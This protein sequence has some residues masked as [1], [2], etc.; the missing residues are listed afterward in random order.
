MNKHERLIEDLA[1]EII[2][3]LKD[4]T[5]DEAGQTLQ[6]CQMYFIKKNVLPE[7]Q[8]EVAKQICNALVMNFELLH[9][10]ET[11]HGENRKH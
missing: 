8:L 1:F 4:K 3:I 10:E 11:K 9:N 2:D 7:Y 6:V 5:F